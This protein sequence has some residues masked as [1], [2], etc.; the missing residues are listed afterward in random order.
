MD[1]AL[2]HLAIH[3][4][5]GGAGGRGCATKRNC[6]LSPEVPDVSVGQGKVCEDYFNPIATAI[7]IATRL[8]ANSATQ[9]GT[10][11]R[12]HCS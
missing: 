1:I 10:V 3:D 5:P 12:T 7:P 11:N 4:L 2:V 9:R 8:S 6:G